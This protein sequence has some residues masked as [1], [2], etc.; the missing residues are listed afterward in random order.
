LY[1]DR[2]RSKISEDELYFLAPT[3]AQPEL[4][5]HSMAVHIERTCGAAVVFTGYHGDKVWD[6]QMNGKYLNDQIIR[7]DISGL[8]L[9]EIRLR[10]GFINVAVPFILARNIASIVKISR[11]AE[12]A[13]W[14]LNNAYDRPIPRRIAESA[15]IDRQLFGMRKKA[16]TRYY[17]YPVTPHLKKRFFEFLRKY[18]GITPAH[19]YMYTRLNQLAYLAMR[20]FAYIKHYKRLKALTLPLI[21]V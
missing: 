2:R 7:G 19:T 8:N 16:V 6:A 10:G 1:L 12:M 15:G 3:Y 4:I 21:S 9:S 14:R 18:Y 20:V 11:S 17:Y 13:P 5:F